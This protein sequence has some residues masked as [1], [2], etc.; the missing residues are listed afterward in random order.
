MPALP[1]RLMRTDNLS[2]PVLMLNQK[3]PDRGK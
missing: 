3:E 1:G 2:K